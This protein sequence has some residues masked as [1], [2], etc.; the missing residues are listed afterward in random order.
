MDRVWSKERAMR[1]PLAKAIALIGAALFCL[2]DV[3][4]GAVERGVTQDGWPY[5]AGGFGVEERQEIE[6]ER[7]DFRLRVTTAVRGSGAYVSGVRIRIAD[8]S[9]RCV[10]D[11]EVDGPWLLIDLPPGRYTV[12]ASLDG[13]TAEQ[14]TSLG[15][16]DRREL[17]FYFPVAAQVLPADAPE[18]R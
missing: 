7:R 5:L 9:W 6:R 12:R 13:K 15:A 11:Q 17:Y 10:F 3:P 1:L 18:C 4:S 2:A 16:R 8:A 14:K